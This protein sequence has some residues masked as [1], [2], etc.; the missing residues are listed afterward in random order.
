MGSDDESQPPPSKRKKRGQNRQRPRAIIPYSQLLCPK[1]H[2]QEGE[3]CRYGDRCR[4]LHDVSKYMVVKP[5]DIGDRCYVYDTYG[6]CAYGAACRFARCHLTADF[7]NVVNAAL[8]DPNRRSPLLNSVPKSLQENLRKKR[9]KFPRSDAFLAN[10]KA[11]GLKVANGGAGGEP[12]DGFPKDAKDGTDLNGACGEQGLED[13]ISGEP[14]S[15]PFEPSGNG[16]GC[17]TG[18]V[19]ECTGVAEA[20]CSSDVKD[21]LSRIEV[22]VAAVEAGLTPS[23]T[24]TDE[25][26]VRLRPAEKKKVRT[27]PS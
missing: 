15:S 14:V 17:E 22:P 19:L 6:K 3:A 16:G 10:L 21:E 5:P 18:S 26:I 8:F 2:L 4:Y 1:L 13:S 7:K 27:Y 9:F 11:G 20:H 24:V 25:G 12:D 23:G